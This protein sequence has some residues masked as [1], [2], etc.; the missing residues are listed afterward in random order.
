M[1]HSIT[2]DG[3]D[4]HHY[5]SLCQ[6]NVT[7][8]RTM[9]A[10]KFFSDDHDVAFGLSADGVLVHGKQKRCHGA[11]TTWP[12]ILI[13]YNLPPEICTHLENPNVISLGTIPGP[14][15]PKD[16]NSFLYPLVEE[17]LEL[18]E[19]V[20]VYDTTSEAMFDLHA[21]IITAFGDIPAISK[22]MSI[23]GHN[24]FAL[25]RCCL[26]RRSLAPGTTTYYVPLHTPD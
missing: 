21:Y 1:Q 11:K 17:F 25:C 2:S 22:L 18:A 15:Q 24:A 9:L 26:I 5:Q 4:G 20:S 8:N 6:K 13:N 14:Q 7:V 23:K 12:L 19:G 10:H 3:F 16:F